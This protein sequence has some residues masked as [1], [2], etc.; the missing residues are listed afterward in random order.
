[1]RAAVRL[2]WLLRSTCGHRTGI[3]ATA[4]FGLLTW[5]TLSACGVVTLAPHAEVA[6]P[7]LLGA[8]VALLLALALTAVLCARAALAD[9]GDLRLR[10][11][12][13][14][15]ATRAQVGII[16]ALDV[17]EAAA[18]GILLG[19]LADA[20]IAWLLDRA[21]APVEPSVPL[22]LLPLLLLT[23]VL[24]TIVRRRVRAAG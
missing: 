22:V 8:V 13:T 6:D 18:P 9:P 20:G 14:T 5:A 3:G 15:G 1:M 23:I 10:I 16:G 4:S 19:V 7:V 12:R 17:V 24:A 2:W 21:G 11:L